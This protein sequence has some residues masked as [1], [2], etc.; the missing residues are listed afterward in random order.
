MQAVSPALLAARPRLPGLLEQVLREAGLDLVPAD[1][2]AE[3]TWENRIS[4]CLMARY[5]DG[6]DAQVFEALHKLTLA[7]VERWIAS[8]LRR[9]VAHLDARELAQDTFVNVYLYPAGFRDDH[10]GSFRV[11]VR[12]IAGNLVR[13]ALSRSRS[14]S[15]QALPESGREP[16]DPNASPERAAVC[17]EQDADLRRAWALLVLLYLSAYEELALRDREA[18]RLV[19]VESLGYFEAGRQL[20]VGRSNMKMIVFR[21]RRRIARRLELHWF[22][23]P[24]VPPE[25][26]SVLRRVG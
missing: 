19:E 15:F 10:V 25:P 12:T 1:G 14:R 4:T 5:R 17:A 11:W 7:S 8:L 18:L 16:A 26:Q 2:E 3:F 13:R 21:A 20:G 9:S 24:S 6:R 23:R 22:V